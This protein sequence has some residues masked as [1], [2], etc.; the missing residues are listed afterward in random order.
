M[1]AVDV[2]LGSP[3]TPPPA[4]STLRQRLTTVLDRAVTSARAWRVLLALLAV[5]VA[6][7]ALTPRPPP[8]ID[9]GWDKLNH[10]LAFAALGFS[11]CLGCGGDRRACLRW[12]AA[13]LAFGGLIE[14]AQLFVPGRSSEWGD[15]LGDA[16]GIAGGAVL[17]L[18]MLR[19]AASTRGR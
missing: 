19:A 11:A 7:L 15:W 4:M 10:T 1:V 3:A 18:A 9:F 14:I 17:A 6:W 13:L 12:S 5:F 2:A 16:L 8:E